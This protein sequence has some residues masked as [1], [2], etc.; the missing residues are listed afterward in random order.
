VGPIFLEGIKNGAFI[1]KKVSYLLQREGNKK[2]TP[3]T[4]CCGAKNNNKSKTKSSQLTK[5]IGI[6]F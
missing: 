5:I 3:Q 1:V 2:K 6:R 4:C